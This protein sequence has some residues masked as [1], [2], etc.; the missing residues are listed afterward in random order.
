L[1][2]DAKKSGTEVVVIAEPEALGDDYAEI[3][4][5]L[6]RIADSKL[7]LAIVPRTER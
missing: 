6:N 7:R 2:E 3:V 5:S 1:C 4:E